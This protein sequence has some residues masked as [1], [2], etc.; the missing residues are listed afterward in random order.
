MDSIETFIK[1]AIAV[2][3]CLAALANLLD[4]VWKIIDKILKKRP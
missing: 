1:I 2:L 4:T 3:N